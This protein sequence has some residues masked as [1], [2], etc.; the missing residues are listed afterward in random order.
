MKVIWMIKTCRYCGEK[1]ETSTSAKTCEKCKSQKREKKSKPKVSISIL[2]MSRI[3]EAHNRK[4]HT[5]YTYG[6]FEKLMKQQ[7]IF[8]LD[9][10]SFEKR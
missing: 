8:I 2:E 1:F 5:H 7:K 9:G 3:I 10:E 6:E 4:Y